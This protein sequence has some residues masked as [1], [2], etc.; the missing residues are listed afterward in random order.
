MHEQQSQRQVAA[1]TQHGAGACA[2]RHPATQGRASTHVAFLAIC[3]GYFVTILD[4]TIVNVALPTIRRQFGATVSDL[5]WVVDGYALVYAALL[6]SAGALGDKLGS[7][8]LFLV[9]LALFTMG[10]ALC[11]ASP[12]LWALQTARVL[13]GVGAAVA[14]PTSLALLRHLFSAPAERA[15]ALGI[16]G[17]VAGIGAGAGPVVGGFLVGG[18]TWRSVFFVNVPI[19]IIAV[20][21]TLRFVSESPR[22]QDRRLDLRA[23][24]A[25]IVALAAVTVAFIEGGASGWTSPLMRSAFILFVVATG[26]FIVVERHATDPMLPLELF[27]S[28]SFSAG[29]A[30]GFLINFGFYGEL[31][32]LSLF[33]QQVRGYSPTITGLALLPQMGMAVVGSWLAGRVMSRV[34]PRSPM[35][36]GLLLGGAGLLSVGLIGKTSPYV[37]LVPM[38]VA[39]GFGM[40]YTMPAMTSAVIESAPSERAGMA[41]GVVNTSRQVGGVIGVALLGA[42]A[43]GHRIALS[44][45]SIALL[46]AGSAFLLGCVLTLLWIRQDQSSR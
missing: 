23:Q 37:A 26:A 27:S 7:K 2:V 29:N 8:R 10:S 36:T 38:L 9:G 46:I 43:G 30:V 35:I 34:G 17:G 42:L 39:I 20:L 12:A 32:L 5:Q 21:L 14:V 25:G 16:W 33:F 6:L 18:L 19:G 45:V 13:Q 15:K 24:V 41:S 11:G 44:G 4:T 3:L 28:S 40:S 1:A 31:F 22:R